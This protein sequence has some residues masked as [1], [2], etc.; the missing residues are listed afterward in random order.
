MNISALNRVLTPE[1]VIS[2]TEA[3]NSLNSNSSNFQS[4]EVGLWEDIH[5][6]PVTLVED[7]V[8]GCTNMASA[9]NM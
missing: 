3:L 1:E 7:T 5:T 6:T 8:W 2:I 9:N 4:N